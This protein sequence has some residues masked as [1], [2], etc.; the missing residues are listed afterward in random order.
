MSLYSIFCK[1]KTIESF[2]VKEHCLRYKYKV[3]PIHKKMLQ[4]YITISCVLC[5]VKFLKI[6]AD[7]FYLNDTFN[8]R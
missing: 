4:A 5:R 2:N 6:S 8:S 1:Q 3:H 7:R